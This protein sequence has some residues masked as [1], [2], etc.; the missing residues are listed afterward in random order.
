[1]YVLKA[2][3]YDNKNESSSKKKTNHNTLNKK[4]PQKTPV[5]NLKAIITC[6]RD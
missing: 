2:K 1:M 4:E 3:T 6:L 5:S